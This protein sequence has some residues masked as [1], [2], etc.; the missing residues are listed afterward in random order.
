M[1]K[2]I[3]ICTILF[4]STILAQ[5]PTAEEQKE[6]AD[7]ENSSRFLALSTH[8]IQLL[9]GATNLSLDAKID[10]SVTLGGNI[11]RWDVTLDDDKLSMT[12]LGI[13]GHYYMGGAAWAQGWYVGG[14]YKK[15][16]IDL[17]KEIDNENYEGSI[18]AN[19]IGLHF[20]YHWQWDFF[21]QDFGGLLYAG[22]LGDTVTLEN[23][24]GDEEEY[25]TPGYG[26]S[27]FG[28]EYKL[29]LVF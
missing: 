5:D 14:S 4:S 19:V 16:N 18:S 25:D 6:I 21:F 17:E 8:P 24:D 29:G 15:F 27:G 22:S 7:K 11:M 2:L 26:F 3:L 1:K 13:Q 28:L 20:G 12:S 23:E 9:I 10:N